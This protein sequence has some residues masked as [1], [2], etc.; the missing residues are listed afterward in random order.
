[1]NFLRLF[2]KMLYF[3]IFPFEMM[4]SAEIFPN[5]SWFNLSRMS[6][7]KIGARNLSKIHESHGISFQ[8]RNFVDFFPHISQVFELNCFIKSW[9]TDFYE[10]IEMGRMTSENICI[11]ILWVRKIL[12]IQLITL[13]DIEK[14]ENFDF[15]RMLKADNQ[16][17]KSVISVIFKILP[18]FPHNFT[19]HNIVMRCCWNSWNFVTHWQFVTIQPAISLCELHDTKF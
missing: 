14:I 6:E 11:K 16:S 8:L 19:L 5:F 13:V 12:N 4:F 3:F 17:Q 7:E 9:K 10:D 15:T 1:M 2:G 18:R